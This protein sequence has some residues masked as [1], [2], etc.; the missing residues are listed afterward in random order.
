MTRRAPGWGVAF[1][2][3]PGAA[4]AFAGL[5]GWAV[6]SE[7]HVQPAPATSAPSATPPSR[8]DLA[9]IQALS[10]QDQ[11]LAALQRRLRALN[12]QLAALTHAPTTPPAP[13]TAVNPVAGTPVNGGA[14]VAPTVGNPVP[15]PTNSG[16]GSSAPASVAPPPPP[17]PPASSAAPPPS[18]VTTGASGTKK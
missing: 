15:P 12:G 17:A 9:V 4:A 18:Q 11:E 14:G 10:R 5:V 6:Q 8:A 16:G 7:P 3:L 13:G 1:V 2:V